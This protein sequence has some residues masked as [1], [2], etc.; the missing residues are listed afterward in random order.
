MT[1]GSF[2]TTVERSCVDDKD[3]HESIIVVVENANSVSSGFQDVFLVRFRAGDVD[4]PQAC[5]FRD[6]AEIDFDRWQIRLDRRRRALWAR[7]S[8]HTL[9]CAY[10]RGGSEH[11]E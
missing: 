1:G 11:R 8:G 2:G 7:G 3:V 6:V 10:R 5:L 4:G 9:K